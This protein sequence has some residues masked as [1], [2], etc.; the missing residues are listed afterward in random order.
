LAPGKKISHHAG[1]DDPLLP[2]W[3]TQQNLSDI[4]ES[5]SDAFFAVDQ[6]WCF[7]YVNRRAEEFWSRCREELLGKNLWEEFPQAAGSEQYR[8]IRRAM[9][10]RTTTSFEAVSPIVG[11]WVA[12][13][14]YPSANGGVAV[15]FDD[16]TER[17]RTEEALRES[18]TRYRT[19]TANIPGAV[20]R[21]VVRE[22]RPEMQFISDRIEEIT[23]HPAS[24]FVADR[25]RWYGSVVHPD[26][27]PNNEREAWHALE[28]KE[29]YNI[30]YRVL[31]ADGGVRWANERGSGI[32]S[33]EGEL[34]WVDGAIFDVTDRKRAEEERERLLANEVKAR[35]QAEERRRLSRE[36]HDRV[37]HDMAL[38]HQSLELHGVLEE[39]DPERAAAKMELARRTVREALDS[40][41]NLS[42]ELRQPEVRRSLE[43]ALADLLRDLV[44]PSVRAGLSVKGDEALVSP[45]TRNQ[46]FLILREA[47]RNAVMHS[48]CARITVKL[49]LAPERVVGYVEDDGRG[50]DEAATRRG[51]GVTSMR[52][53]AALGGAAL[54]ISPSPDGGTRVAVTVVP[55][56]GDGG[57]R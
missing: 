51:G 5:I 16:V 28:R 38:V 33:E 56:E 26:D 24:D 18:E 27:L 42:M 25:V 4:L 1:P 30:E 12:G 32:F 49:D 21:A 44:P 47:V 23:G 55:E 29:A 57:G 36:L 50:F 2:E 8:E 52:E 37:A 48:G 31:H 46:L 43:S 41:R 3:D 11:V 19:L 34:L 53:R 13:R 17:K 6:E 45:E 15:Y 20:F 9:E 54:E 39:S 22:K 14:A 40:I 10:E 7:T 35:A